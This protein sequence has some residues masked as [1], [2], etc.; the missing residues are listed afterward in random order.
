MTA[1]IFKALTLFLAILSMSPDADAQA[2]YISSAR[3]PDQQVEILGAWDDEQPDSLVFAP[4]GRRWDELTPVEAVGFALDTLIS[5]PKLPDYFFLPAV[6]DHFEFLDTVGLWDPIFS[7]R[8]EMRWIEE[9]AAVEANMNRMRYN[10]FFK[11]PQAVRYNLN[12][13]LKAPKQYNV[14]INPSDHKVTVDEIPVV[15]PID[16]TTLVAEEIKKRHWIRE[17]RASLQFSQAYVSPNWYQGGN[18]NLNMLG[19]LYYNVKLNQ[20]YHPNLLFDFTAQYKLGLN[21]A[22]DDSLRNY[23]ISD[24]LLQLNTTFGVKAAKRWYYSFTGQFKTQLLNSYTSNTRNL[25]SA[26]LS[27]AELTAG[28]GMTYNYA[29]SKN[30]FRFDM[31]LAPI[32]YNLKMCTNSRL[33]ETNYG[34]KEGHTTVSKYG[35]TAELKLYWKI[36]YNISYNSRLFAFSDYSQ[37]Q[38]DW[39]HTLLFEI[40]KFLTTQVYAHLRY[41]T[42]GVPA[43]DTKWKKLQVKEILSIGFAYKFSSI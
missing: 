37:M 31:S 40:N 42:R 24:D 13:M 6:Y 34:I 3:V 1:K 14:S 5:L 36:A 38:A 10:L 26:F 30:T 29:N 2:Q 20:N 33:N 9:Q 43:P 4:D 15:K 8:P 35:S 12:G 22:P 11:N 21:S 41:D 16:K 32:S 27:P 18:N 19:Q 17:F 28:I 23:S 39:E 25:R 7:D